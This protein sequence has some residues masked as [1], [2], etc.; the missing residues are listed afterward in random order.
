MFDKPVYNQN[1]IGLTEGKRDSND[2]SAGPSRISGN[3]PKLS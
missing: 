2:R 1:C 3:T